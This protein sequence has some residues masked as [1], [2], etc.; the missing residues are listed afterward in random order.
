MSP[1]LAVS[2]FNAVRRIGLVSRSAL[3]QRL[4]DEPVLLPFVKQIDRRPRD[5]IRGVF[6][7][8][9][10]AALVAAGGR[11]QPYWDAQQQQ[12]RADVDD[13][14]SVLLFE[15]LSLLQIEQ[16]AAA[17]AQGVALTDRTAVVGGMMVA[18]WAS[19]AGPVSPAT[20][21]LLT[22]LDVGVEYVAANPAVVGSGHAEALV[23]ALAQHFSA[24]IPDASSPG[25]YGPKAR[26]GE[27]LAAGFLR[28][29]LQAALDNPELLYDEPRMSALVHATLPPVVAALPSTL[30][31]QARWRDVT[32]ALLGPSA[33]AALETVARRPAAFLGAGFDPEQAVGAVTV[34]LLKTAATQDL[35]AV[36]TKTV[37][38][39]L[40]DAVLNVAADRPELLLA[41]AGRSA[42]AAGLEVFGRLCHAVAETAAQL[43][44]EL[45]AQLLAVAVDVLHAQGTLLQSEQPWEQ[46]VAAASRRFIDGLSAA[47]RDGSVDLRKFFTQ[48]ELVALARAVFEQATR[49][50]EM[51]SASGGELA[52]LVSSIA[53]GIAADEHELLTRAD[54]LELADAIAEE[55]ARNPNRLVSVD[56][57]T[58]GGELVT[59][60]LRGL[61][62]AA[63]ADLR[64]ARGGVLHGETLRAAI[65]S[66]L[67]A[68]A[69][70]ADAALKAAGALEALATELCAVV[71]AHAER[72]G[73]EEWLHL[74]S[75]LLPVVLA[76]GETPQITLAF[77]DE[78]LSGH[79]P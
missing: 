43:D 35:G 78:V 11:L 72:L 33:R 45:A 20:R 68:A 1:L 41:R 31:E 63:A 66:L 15:A 58:P 79:A 21:I 16:E 50:A 28:A 53:A 59:R 26:F 65:L 48:R 9:A 27:R 25:D 12:P 52:R 69:G 60:L 77:A 6:Q 64:R 10:Y 30:T 75:A 23:G 8:P 42:E 14:E 39:T 71:R 24:L 5:T 34:A 73:S 19:G 49:G 76:E 44:P 57:D 67:Q 55:V 47:T 70:Q 36:T 46:I 2:L 32:D 54:W 38:R 74:Y 7:D 40:H 22:V 13:A 51:L 61:L 4:R 56:G 3:E 37:L 18:Q 17:A 62:R 29:G